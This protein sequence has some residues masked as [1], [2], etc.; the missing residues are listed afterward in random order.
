MTTQISGTTGVSLVQDGVVVQADLAANVVGN[1]PAFGAVKNLEQSLTSTPSKILY[2]SEEFDTGGCYDAATS[3]FQPTVAGYYFISASVQSSV[4]TAALL[5][6]VYKNG[7]LT[8][9]GAYAN[10][11]LGAPI[12]N[13]AVL[14]YMNGTTDYLEIY[15]SQG[16]SGNTTSNGT[17]CYFKGFLARAA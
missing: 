13:L 2:Q 10:T 6:S 8:H 11:T 4:S 15:G 3:R 5:L 1:G 7:V 14:M 16:T 12:V 17:A 9:N